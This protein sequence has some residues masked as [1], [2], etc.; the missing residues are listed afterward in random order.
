[1]KK[2]LF[3]A[4]A[5]AGMV[6]VADVQ[7]ANTVGYTGLTIKPGLNMIGTSFFKVD[8]MGRLDINATFSDCKGKSIAGGGSGVADEIYVYDASVHSYAAN[9][10][11]FYNY[12]ESP[13]PD[14]DFH[15][16][17]SHTDDFRPGGA[18][19]PVGGGFWYRNRAGKDITITIKCP[20]KK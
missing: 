20:I 5:A 18:H 17:D 3:I 16:L 2:L 1:M 10:F 7:S 13:D 19:V 11:Y 9:Q 15:W 8:D 14:Y 6:A 4:A 12:P